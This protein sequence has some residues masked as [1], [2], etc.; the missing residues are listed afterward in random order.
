VLGLFG[1]GFID[2]R[3]RFDDAGRLVPSW[4]NACD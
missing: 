3:Y 1:T 4:R 2:G